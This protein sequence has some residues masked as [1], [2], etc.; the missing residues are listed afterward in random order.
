MRFQVLG[1]LSLSRGSE[2]VVLQ[3]SKP[4]VLLAALLLNANSLVS[5]D[6]LLRVVWGEDQPATAKAALQTCVLRLRRL[7]TKHGVTQTPIE[8]VPGGYRVI[9]SAPH[10]DLLDFRERRA[11]ADRCRG[12]L[13]AELRI[14]EEAL[15][16]WQGPL[17]TN[18][19]SDALHRDEVPQLKEEHLRAL[20]RACDLRLA[21]GN[22]GRA[23]GDLWGVTRTHPGHERFR[24]QLIE[25]LYRTGRQDEA[26]AEYQRIKA[27]L[28]EEL[29][30]DPS[31]TLRKLELAILRGEDLGPASADGPPVRLA[32]PAGTRPA[33]TARAGEP[34]EA[35][36]L[37]E[38][39]ELVVTRADRERSET[40]A[41][42]DV[43]KG[44]RSSGEPPG[45][46][47]VG[48]LG[49]E[50]AALGGSGAA[51]TTETAG[52]SPASLSPVRPVPAFSGRAREIKALAD[53]LEG[54]TN[55][56]LTLLCGA[57]GVGKT[58]LAV[59][60]ADLARSR[61][62]GGQSVLLMV[63]PDGSP[64]SARE[65]AAIVAAARASRDETGAGGLLLVLDDVVDA[66]Q[67]RPLLPC[68]S[69]DALIVTSRMGLAGLVATHG[70]WVQ[71]VNNLAPEESRELMVAVLGAERVAEEPEAADQLA[72]AC[73]HHP[74]ALRILTA[75][76]LTRPT[77]R[78]AD[79][80]QWLGDDPVARL[81]LPDDSRMSVRRLLGTAID[82]LDP[83]QADAFLRVAALPR[84]GFSPADGAVALGTSEADAEDVLEQLA[85][86][87]FLEEGP[88]VPYRMHELLRAYARGVVEPVSP[89]QRV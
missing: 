72:A 29:G 48:E 89:K 67:V 82:R 76:L 31:A 37:G 39:A 74:L 78:L 14:L 20:E 43:A 7:F 71:R 27:Y 15:E 66:E 53:R 6:Y 73:G 18:V 49:S 34:G 84:T 60:T 26:L 80:V 41:E 28:R 63:H 11:G 50:D 79:G 47:R 30:V 88:P 44:T 8:A 35:V 68:P 86:A 54:A 52:I 62:P 33:T 22:C 36:E 10:L 3:P 46:T 87:G 42:L 17:L 75:R 85:D 1:P 12:D 19:R 32:L 40:P 69:G 58:A 9:A 59:Q 4:T 45:S 77:L 21:L 83:R 2:V 70:G 61:F 23:L 5:G 25:A 56:D 16:L 81:T 65:A 13:E 38:S 57:P 55:T 24:E 64:R 51:G